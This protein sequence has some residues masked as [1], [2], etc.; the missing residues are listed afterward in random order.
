[1]RMCN[2][3]AQADTALSAADGSQLFGQC[4]EISIKC[5]FESQCS[6]PVVWLCTLK[7]W[8]EAVVDV[9]GAGPIALTEFTAKHLHVPT[10]GRQADRRTHDT[11]GRSKVET[12]CHF[13]G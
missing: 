2:R 5:E 6:S 8:Q 7:G 1:M 12:L 3:H 11:N 13:Q 9:D 10:A 4:C